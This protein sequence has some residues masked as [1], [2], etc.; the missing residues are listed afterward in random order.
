MRTKTKKLVHNQMMEVQTISPERTKIRVALIAAMEA[1]HIQ[2]THISTA[3]KHLQLVYAMQ[4]EI[5]HKQT[6]VA[7]LGPRLGFKYRRQ[8][9]LKISKLDKKLKL[10]KIK[11]NKRILKKYARFY[12]RYIHPEDRHHL[13]DNM[14]LD[15]FDALIP[16][17]VGRGSLRVA[18]ELKRTDK[19]L[20]EGQLTMLEKM[21]K[22]QWEKLPDKVKE[23]FKKQKELKEQT[24]TNKVK[25]VLKQK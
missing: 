14:T 2:A 5:H 10:L 1:D 25:Q 21:S 18:E 15:Q 9:V 20:A 13:L 19:L 8:C 3:A 22:E 16:Q 4:S 24:K 17:L 11:M 7:E 6:I 23:I 12:G